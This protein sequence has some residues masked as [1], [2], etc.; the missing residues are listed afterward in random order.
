MDITFLI[1][2][3]FDLSLG[4]KT[5][6]RDFYEWYLNQPTGSQH[7]KAIKRLKENIKKDLDEGLQNWSDFEIGL[8][9]FTESFGNQDVDDFIAAYGDAVQ[10]LNTYLLGIND[11]SIIQRVS[12]KQWDTIRKNLCAFYSDGNPEERRFFSEM[13]QNEQGVGRETIFH[14]VSFNYTLFL[15]QF[16]KMISQRPLVT[17]KRGAEEKKTILDPNVFHV[18][19]VLSD[20]PIVGVSNEEQMLNTEFRKNE[21]IFTSLIKEKSIRYIG[22]HRY[23]TLQ[24]TINKSRI[25]CLWGLSLGASDAHWWEYVN[26]WLA[27]NGDHHIF[28]FLRTDDPP[29]GILVPDLLRKRDAAIKH[30][31]NYTNF[32]NEVF[33]NLRQRVHVIF[34]TRRVLT[35]PE[36]PD[37]KHD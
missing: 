18:H 21:D 2:N 10:N 32:S 19:G 9:K 27:A 31:L 35:I 4:C 30:L 1:G 17:W 24:E 5:S 14:F 23:S 15:D 37:A 20:Y 25:I 34:N 3:G 8:G 29:R 16:A 7:A 12:E 36:M 33:A 26:N 6:Y 13:R 28:I 22:S 11:D